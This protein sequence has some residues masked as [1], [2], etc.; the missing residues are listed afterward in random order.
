MAAWYHSDRKVKELLIN[1]LALVVV[2]ISWY[3]V[4]AAGKVLSERYLKT[5]DLSKYQDQQQRHNGGFWVE[6]D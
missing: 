2:L 5:I 1:T 3:Y 4:I 6:Q